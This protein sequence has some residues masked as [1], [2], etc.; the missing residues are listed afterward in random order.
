MRALAILVVGSLML[1]PATAGAQP[2][3]SVES[4]IG[5]D[6]ATTVASLSV[7]LNRGNS[8]DTLLVL[9]RL[10]SYGYSVNSEARADRA[11][12]SWQQS[13]RLVVDGIVGA[14]TLASLRLTATATAPAVRT[15]PPPAPTAVDGDVESI[16]RAVWPD[17][18]EDRAVR[19]A[20]RES[21]LVPTVRNACCFGLFQIHWLAHRSW[22]TS[23]FGVTRPEQLYD[24]T[25][26]ATVALA[27]YEAAGWG[28]WSL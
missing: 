18:L 17:E 7:S 22:L 4:G 27:L 19:I 15:T 2:A 20:M 16:I 28:P 6:Q 25:L 13:N 9:D 10:H 14:Q 11:I 8:T 26:N 24:P 21:R 3:V 1:L 5:N 23:D 12:R